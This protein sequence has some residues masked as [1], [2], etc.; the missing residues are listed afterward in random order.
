M[1][2]KSTIDDAKAVSGIQSGEGGA[3]H[4]DTVQIGLFHI[5]SSA[6]KNVKAER[7][8]GVISVLKMNGE[9]RLTD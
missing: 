3:I 8:G 9:V 4:L 5:K 1:I 2:D 7:N 6:I